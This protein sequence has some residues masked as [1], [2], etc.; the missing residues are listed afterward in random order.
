MRLIGI[1]IFCLLSGITAL[2]QQRSYKSTDMP[3]IVRFYPNPATSYIQFDIPQH[4]VKETQLLVFNF[5]GKKVLDLP[6]TQTKARVDMNPL[7]RGIYI[8]QLKDKTGKIIES[9]KFQIEK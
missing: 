7:S 8:F 1:I 3:R 9:G 4:L 6:A 2:A 5:L